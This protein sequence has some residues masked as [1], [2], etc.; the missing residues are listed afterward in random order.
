[1]HPTIKLHLDPEEFAPIERLA[2][3]LHVTPEAVV[4]AGLDCIMRRVHAAEVR[5]EIA[6]LQTGR[7]EGL[8]PWADSARGVHIYESKR[9]E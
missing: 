8:P 7:Q 5:K 2:R 3:E 4:Y 9:D 6:D 1:M